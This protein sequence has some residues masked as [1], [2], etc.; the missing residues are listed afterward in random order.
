[1]FKEVAQ[2]SGQMDPQTSGQTSGVRGISLGWL[3]VSAF[4]AP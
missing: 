4:F 2:A 1:M 3:L